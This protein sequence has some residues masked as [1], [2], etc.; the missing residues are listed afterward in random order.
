MQHIH[1]YEYRE[2]QP[3]NS[4]LIRDRLRQR[5]KRTFETIDDA[6]AW[7]KEWMAEVQRPAS[8]WGSDGE[9]SRKTGKLEFTRSQLEL[10]NDVVDGFWS[11]PQHIAATLIPCPPRVIPGFPAPAPCPTGRH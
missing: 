4:E 11:G 3:R 10:G 9:E 5:P 2:P 7:H 1:Q 6:V 8:C